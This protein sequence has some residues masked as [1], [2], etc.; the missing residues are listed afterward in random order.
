MT[1]K[2]RQK[3][4]QNCEGEVDFDVIFCPFCG[5]DLLEEKDQDLLSRSEESIKALSPQESVASLY[6]PPY[7]AS[8][9][10]EEPVVEKTNDSLFLPLLLLSLSGW[11]FSLSLL[12]F[13]FSDGGKLVLQFDATMWF[14]YL[15]A[16]LFLGFFG[17]KTLYKEGD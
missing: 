13:V 12:L 9:V 11:F 14:F 5:H 17:W 8:S 1:T 10:E 6:P 16:S 4:W 7:G 3:L 2:K 15:I